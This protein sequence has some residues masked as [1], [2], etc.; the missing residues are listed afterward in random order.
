MMKI[1]FNTIFLSYLLK[2]LVRVGQNGRDPGCAT[3]FPPLKAPFVIISLYLKVKIQLEYF[4]AFGEF[5]WF[6]K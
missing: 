6:A 2:D 4:G 3:Y 1:L 5:K